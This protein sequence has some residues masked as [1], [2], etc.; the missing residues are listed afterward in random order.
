MKDHNEQE[1][2]QVLLL[3]YWRDASQASGPPCAWRFS[4]ENPNTG[5]RFGF[6]SVEA[7]WK[8][9][10]AQITKDFPTA[11]HHAVNNR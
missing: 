5:E 7:L 1:V 9:I 11:D 8:F 4:I 6:T 2:Y 10:M 3:R